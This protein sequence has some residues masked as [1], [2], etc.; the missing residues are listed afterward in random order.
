M[1]TSGFISAQN[2]TGTKVWVVHLEN[3]IHG[4]PDF[5]LYTPS[6]ISGAAFDEWEERYAKATANA[7]AKA[8]AIGEKNA[9]VQPEHNPSPPDSK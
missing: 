2:P 1:C 7:R 4:L 9:R 8:K 5:N 6:Y 3:R